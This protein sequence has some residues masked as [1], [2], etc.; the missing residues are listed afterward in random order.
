MR[1]RVT[2]FPTVIAILDILGGILYLGAVLSSV[3]AS[4]TPQTYLQ[5]HN[6]NHVNLRSGRRQNRVIKCRARRKRMEDLVFFP[7]GLLGAELGDVVF[8]HADEATI[9]GL[10]PG[11]SKRLSFTGAGLGL[12]PFALERATLL[13]LLVRVFGGCGLGLRKQ[14]RVLCF[15]SL[16]SQSLPLANH[17]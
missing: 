17:L 9:A 8:G 15:E 4:T 7:F 5:N 14:F 1:E 12:G 3:T 16:A 10:H 6:T 11:D 13:L 2:S